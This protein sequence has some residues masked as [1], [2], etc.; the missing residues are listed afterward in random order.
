MKCSGM[1]GFSL[2]FLRKSR[3]GVAID[4]FLMLFV[5]NKVL[6]GS[7]VISELFAVQVLALKDISRCKK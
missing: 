6:F 3:E 7:N 1:E 4:T 5:S 2:V